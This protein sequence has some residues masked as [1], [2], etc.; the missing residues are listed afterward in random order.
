[1]P[2]RKRKVGE[3]EKQCK[4]A[5]ALVDTSQNLCSFLSLGHFSEDSNAL[6]NNCPGEIWGALLWYH[7]FDDFCLFTTLVSSWH[8]R[9]LVQLQLPCVMYKLLWFKFSCGLS[10]NT[11][12]LRIVGDKDNLYALNVSFLEQKWNLLR[13]STCFNKPSTCHCQWRPTIFAH[14][15][16]KWLRAEN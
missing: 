3:T 10:S 7:I 5:Y 6:S 2:L 4:N 9:H 16:W 14:S 15:W 12:C 1:M 11:N 8:L 13:S